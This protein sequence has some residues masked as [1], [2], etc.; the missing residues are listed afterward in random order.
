EIKARFMRGDFFGF[1]PTFK[2]TI[3]GNHKPSL[4]C[5]GDAERD[6]FN[7]VPF[8]QR[9][10]QV[11]PHLEEKLLAELPGILAWSVQGCLDWR[12]HGLVKPNSMIRA[13]EEY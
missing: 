1:R 10:K 2:L 9:P 12:E 5:V 7:I 3:I 6:R 4:G 8:T 13:T 11:D